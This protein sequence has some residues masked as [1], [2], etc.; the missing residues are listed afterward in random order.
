MNQLELLYAAN[1]NI[2]SSPDIVSRFFAT[3]T[4]ADDY[5]AAD[6]IIVE[7][8][9]V[10]SSA[11]ELSLLDEFFSLTGNG[12]RTLAENDYEYRPWM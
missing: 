12:S 1:G 4:T 9:S 8:H 2:M 7:L 6:I 3:I 11:E 5:N 10:I